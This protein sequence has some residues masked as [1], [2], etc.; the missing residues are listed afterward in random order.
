MCLS[1]FQAIAEQ[2][3][4]LLW[5]KSAAH[6]RADVKKKTQ[7]RLT[8]AGSGE[9]LI[10]EPREEGGAA[11]RPRAGQPS[12][13]SP[14]PASFPST[15]Q[16]SFCWPPPNGDVLDCFPHL[17]KGP[18]PASG[19]WQ[20]RLTSQPFILLWVCHQLLT[21]W[22]SV[23]LNRGS[24]GGGQSPTSNCPTVFRSRVQIRK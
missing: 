4:E 6:Q 3:E 21:K 15:T 5:D 22:H 20:P 8:P 18:F 12:P 17:W 13:E 7:L 11:R 14:V 9:S 23:P 10:S 1:V 2:W 16:R 19:F 24:G